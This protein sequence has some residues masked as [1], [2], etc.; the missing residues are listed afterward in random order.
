MSAPSRDTGHRDTIEIESTCMSNGSLWLMRI[1][2]AGIASVT[3]GMC[4]PIWAVTECTGHVNNIWTG[5]AGSVWVIMDNTVPWYLGPSDTNLKNI[6]SSAT[7]ALV[8]AYS[9]TVRFQADGVVCASGAARNDV[10]G[11]YLN[12]TP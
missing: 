8:T 11:M 12:H 5:D 9:V 10:V 1:A 2:R 3:L 7:T 4:T 6:L